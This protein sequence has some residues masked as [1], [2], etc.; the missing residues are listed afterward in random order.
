MP[1]YLP[2][3]FPIPD[4]QH[5]KYT[6]SALTLLLMFGKHTRMCSPTARSIHYLHCFHHQLHSGHVLAQNGKVQALPFVCWRG[7]EDPPAQ[8]RFQSP[9]YLTAGLVKQIDVTD[10]RPG[11]SVWF[12]LV[13]RSVE[14]W[15]SLERN[16]SRIEC[17]LEAKT[18]VSNL[19]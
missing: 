6:L 17:T 10:K 15:P 14:F 1:T 4:A 13:A 9:R 19:T 18:T 8:S 3:C 7:G 5:N 11:C 12:K 2:S 16:F